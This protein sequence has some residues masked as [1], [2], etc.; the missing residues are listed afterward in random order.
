MKRYGI[1]YISPHEEPKVWGKGGIG[2][3]WYG[4]ESPKSSTVSIASQEVPLRDILERDPKELIGEKAVAQFG[5]A[6]PLVKILTPSKRLSVQ[7]HDRKDEL[8]VVTSVEEGTFGEG[9]ELILGFSSEALEKYGREV[10]DRYKQALYRFGEK[11]DELITVL[12]RHMEKSRIEELGDAYVAACQIPGRSADLDARRTEFELVRKELN[13]FYDIRRVRPG[14]V[15]PVPNKT[16]HA[17]GAG[18]EV[19]EPQIPGDT[20]STEDGATYPVRYA[21]PGFERQTVAKVLDV[22]RVGELR[23]E[24]APFCSVKVLRD[25]S[26]IKVE[27]LPGGFEEKGLAVERISIQKGHTLRYSEARSAHMIAGLS[28][29]GA[30]ISDAQSF[31]I[32]LAQAGGKIMLVPGCAGAYELTAHEDLCLVDTFIPV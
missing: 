1:M 30:L 8:W 11:L 32:P 24:K 31:D 10:K 27:R 17:L 28:G 12:E 22:E 26:G 5:A 13:G 19:V 6:L 16:L 23:A 29:K 7:F 2:E 18:I 14:D 4:A 9:G 15:V 25:Q 3:Y 20:Q 21:F